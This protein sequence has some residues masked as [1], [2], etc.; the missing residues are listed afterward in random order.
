MSATT[1]AGPSVRAIAAGETR[2]LRHSVL[3]PSQPF[4]AT[5]YAGDDDPATRHLGAFE[6]A[7]LVGVASLYRA[8]RSGDDERGCQPRDG[9][10]LRGMATAPE[11]RGQ[12][13]GRALL[14][15][16]VAHVATKGGGLLWCNAR[17]PAVGFYAAAGL[18]VVGDEF[19]VVGIGPHVVM[20]VRV[21]PSS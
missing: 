16:C 20:L 2:A 4:D 3:R 10:R 15:A 12:G 7:R 1:P 17:M 6:G 19:D 9:W 14:A 21:P 11:V 18:E 5:A 13:V 8:N